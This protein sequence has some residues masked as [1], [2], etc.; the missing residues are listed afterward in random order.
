[1]KIYYNKEGRFVKATGDGIFKQSENTNIIQFKF[2]N[3]IP[4]NSVVFATFLLPFPDNSSQYGNYNAQSLLL[5]NVVDEDDGGYM[6]QQYMPGGYLPVSGQN[7]YVSARINLP[8]GTITI[9]ENQPTGLTRTITIGT[10]TYVITYNA[11]GYLVLTADGETPISATST[12]S[13]IINNKIY[14]IAG[15]NT[16]LELID[17]LKVKTTEQVH[18]VIENSGDYVASA[19]LPE[20]GEQILYELANQH[21]EITEISRVLELKQDKADDNLSTT[22][23]TV[24]GAINELKSGVDTLD[25]DLNT[26]TTG[27][28]ARLTTAETNITNINAE[29][30]TQNGDILANTRNI[31]N[32][33]GRVTSL[34]QTVVTGT[35]YIG[36]M[37]GSSLPTATQ[38]TNYVVTEASRQPKGGDYIYF[39]LQISGQTDKNYKYTYSEITGWGDLEHPA[40]IP[41]IEKA[42]NTETGIVKGS[43]GSNKAT[44]ISILNGV[45]DE[46]YIKDNSNTQRGLSAY[47][48]ALD[49][50][51]NSTDEQNPGIASRLTTAEGN[52]SDNTRDIGLLDTAV[53]NIINGTTT[54]PKADSANKDGLNRNIASTYMTQSA[55]ATK[56][57]LYDYALPRTFNDVSYIGEDSSFVDT[58]PS[59][60]SPIYSINVSSVGSSTLFHAD[61]TIDNA[62]FQLSNKNSYSDTVYISATQNCS[63]TYRLITEI[64]TN[65]DWHVLNIELTD[66]IDMTANV[67]KKI[68]FGATM[69][70]LQEVLDIQDGD[71]I[72]QTFEVQTTTSN[73]ITFNIYSNQTYPSTFYLNTT[74][75]SIVV[76]QGYIGELPVYELSGTLSTNDLIFFF[77]GDYVIHENVSA[78]FKLN[79]SLYIPDGANVYVSYNNTVIRI[80][81]PYNYTTSSQATIENLA[82]AYKNNEGL[83]FEGVFKTIGADMCILAKF[84]N[85][86]TVISQYTSNKMDKTNPTGTGSL[87]LNRSTNGAV[88]D[89]SVAVGYQNTATA[90]SSF[91][92]GAY[93][94]V[95]G[96]YAHAEGYSTTAF[97]SGAH[98]EGWNSSANGYYSHA[99]G[100]GTTAQKQSQHTFGEYN[101]AETGSYGQRGDYVEIVGNGTANNSRSNARTLDWSGN[102][103]LA[104]K[105]TP[106]GGISDGNNANYSLKVPDTTS[107]T[108]N[109]TIATTDQVPQTYVSSVNGNSGAITGIATTTQIQDINDKIPSAASS[110]N[111]LTDTNFVN[112]SISSNTANFI[113]TFADIPTFNAYSGTVTNNDYAFVMNSVIED[114]GNDWATFT[115]LNAYD[116][117]LLTEFDYAWV[118][119]G[120]NFDLYRFDIV[121]QTWGLRVQNTAKAS[122]TLNTA[123]NRYKATVSGSTVTWAYEY[124]LNNSSFTAQQWAAINSGITSSLVTQ[125]GTNQTNIGNLNTNKADKSATVSSVSYDSNANK[126]QQTING[127]TTDVMTFGSNAFNSTPIPTTYVSQITPGTGIN[128]DSNNNNTISLD[129]VIPY[130]TTAPTAN[131]T[132]GLK[133]VVLSSEPATKY[134]GYLYI[135]TA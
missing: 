53:G 5:E 104:G 112:S 76:A 30:L 54:V 121:N 70:Y 119:N 100:L 113:G 40:E 127:T 93:T 108:G 34:E 115:D 94:S 125:I 101:I 44:E 91:A 77:P 64:Y 15:T 59:G 82:Q 48:N 13:I 8:D 66:V 24:V 6:W 72:S 4:N 65:N 49:S 38:L 68:N 11:S 14:L 37:T 110:S 58:I 73:A 45:L 133:I 117:T 19:V 32:I 39:T 61:K 41:P 123:Y 52:I 130:T 22:T 96:S 129:G 50:E 75:Q 67:I 98:A 87:S 118:I 103:W 27:I 69:S 26:P 134:D 23:K 99:E 79:Y 90:N 80:V 33:D 17:G 85:L 135:I 109:K 25:A 1:M 42:T 7:A 102:E 86:Q 122:V 29:Q 12:T 92:E 71:I 35:T 132:T 31:S 74:A 47:I 62:Q 16:L 9:T 83:M 114:N 107:W 78:I 120:S 20:L 60:S 89:N 84:D 10:K 56:Q 2:D 124:T 18:F 105:I 55:G 3:S 51:L 21:T 97:S 46:V 95:Y 128:I 81:T 57:N 111:K 36:T 106:T 43:Y 116:K 28:K 88:G 126:L 131:N 63:V